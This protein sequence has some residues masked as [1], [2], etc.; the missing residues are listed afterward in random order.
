MK[1]QLGIVVLL[2]IAN[3]LLAQVVDRVVYERGVNYINCQFTKMSLSE[4]AGRPHL[5][6]YNKE[7]GN[8]N[9][10]FENMVVFLKTRPTGVMIENLELAYFID[11]YK[12]KYDETLT[13]AELY[14][15]LK[16]ELF[17]EA[18]LQNFRIKH[19][20]VFADF[21]LLINDY[22]INLFRLKETVTETIDDNWGDIVMVEE[23][24]E[25][26]NNNT[27]KT[28]DT[29]TQAE[30]STE[31]PKSPRRIF[32][33]FDFGEGEE[34]FSF[35]SWFF[36]FSLL[37]ASLAVL[38]YVLLP[39]YEKIEKAKVKKKGDEVHPQAL[40]LEAEIAI[41]EN[42]NRILRQEIEKM[43]LDLDD[44]ED[45]FRSI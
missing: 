30:G 42:K 39:Y 8:H 18:M 13:N 6:A 27:N 40:S 15:I 5:T 24:S 3:S 19:E 9:C 2:F 10:S 22:L 37:F 26:S 29:V 21:E 41:L 33:P 1:R 17:K 28:T 45:T 35:S 25:P 4:Q 44:Y 20:A 38:L 43:H 31:E 12:D 14:S 23:G 7:V 32:T 16:N 34:I 36:R 11:S